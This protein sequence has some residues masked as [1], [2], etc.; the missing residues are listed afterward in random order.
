MF[1]CYGTIVDWETGILAALRPVL[2][3]ARVQ[4]ADEAAL[5][6]FARFEQALEAGPYRPYR[7]VLQHVLG[8]L[9]AELGF[10]PTAD[11]QA[12]F[13]ASA[14][15]WP[16]FADSAPSLARLQAHY[17]L[18]ILSNV[19]AD[20]FTATSRRLGI[21]F[22]H[23]FTAQAIG[24]YKPNP[25]NFRYA[26]E[27]LPTPVD[28]VLHVAQSL[29]HD[30]RPAQRLGLKTAWIDRRRGRPGSGATPAATARPDVTFPDLAS[31]ARAA[32]D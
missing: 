31:L 32:L 18:A 7:D 5:A 30:I 27:H 28:R 2:A 21:D 9:G 23:V 15:D 12:A 25:A 3:R 14:A 16:P 13:A 22:D 24:S 11:E 8:R 19:D 26:L 29:F 6:L 10:A 1:D 4:L 20:L 17:Q